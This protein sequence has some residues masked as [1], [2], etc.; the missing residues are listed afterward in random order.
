MTFVDTGEDTATRGRLK[1]LAK[2][3]KPGETLCFTYVNGVDDINILAEIDFHKKQGKHA[4][5]FAVIL[6]DRHGSLMINAEP[7]KKSSK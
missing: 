4:S 3:L 1:R 6:P 7:V 2:Y 5:V